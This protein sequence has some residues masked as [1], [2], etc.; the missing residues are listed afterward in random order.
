MKS[1]HILLRLVLASRFHLKALVCIMAIHT[2]F[3]M[4]KFV[5]FES[6]CTLAKRTL[7]SFGT[8][9]VPIDLIQIFRE[10]ANHRYFLVLHINDWVNLSFR[11]HSFQFEDLVSV[12]QYNSFQILKLRIINILCCLSTKILSLHLF[13]ITQRIIF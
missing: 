8:F 5:K 11:R 2:I 10:V 1:V 12:Q 4:L 9:K 6:I 7:H 13:L 3:Q